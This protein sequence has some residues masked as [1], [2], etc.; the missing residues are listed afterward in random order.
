MSQA[1]DKRRAT[2]LL[3]VVLE[4]CRRIQ[5]I[6][7]R[8]LS[9]RRKAA[10]VAPKPVDPSAPKPVDLKQPA[11]TKVEAEKAEADALERARLCEEAEVEASKMRKAMLAIRPK[12]DSLR[13]CSPE[14]AEKLKGFSFLLDHAGP[15]ESPYRLPVLS[16]DWRRMQG[17]LPRLAEIL[18]ELYSQRTKRRRGLSDREKKLFKCIGPENLQTRDNKPLW[19]DS[20]IQRKLKNFGVAATYEQFKPLVN[21]VRKVKKIPPPSHT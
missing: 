20:E 12:I 14:F 4:S 6:S 3:K 9:L 10:P 1:T 11:L 21:R 7:N 18:K 2:D 17:E 15:A 19:D 13:G 8:E 16:F 5:K